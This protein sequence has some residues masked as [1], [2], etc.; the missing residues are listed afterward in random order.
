MRVDPP[1]CWIHPIVKKKKNIKVYG[2]TVISVCVFIRY[3]RWT[4]PCT[5]LYSIAGL[6]LH[7]VFW[8]ECKK[9]VLRRYPCTV[10]G[11]PSFSLSFLSA[12]V[13]VFIYLSG[14]GGEQSDIQVTSCPD[15]NAG[16][17]NVRLY[18][19]VNYRTLKN[20]NRN[21]ILEWVI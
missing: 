14:E 9:S 7:F 17:Q 4:V 21:R 12:F 8:P 15:K 13:H 5:N 1:P 2:N 6:S 11:L 18:Q 16:A 20:R 10:V 19:Y 3:R